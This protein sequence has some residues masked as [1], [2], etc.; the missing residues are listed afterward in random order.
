MEQLL[1]HI[2]GDYAAQSDWMALN[3]SKRSWPCLVHVLIYTSCFLLLTTSWKALL[4][5]GVVHFILDR[6]HGILHRLIWTKNHMAPGL[7]YVPFE[8]C[9]ATGYYDNLIN[10]VT[11]H[12]YTKEVINGNSPRLN[13]ITLWLYIIT[14]NFL[15]LATNY[16][17]LTYLT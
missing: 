1:V 3:K 9:K 17:A 14:D 6:Y 7:K 13:Y 10:E 5:I 15:H 12:P 4:V 16:L 2:L 11:G 8:K